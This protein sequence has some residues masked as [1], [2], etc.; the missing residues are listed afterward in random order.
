LV[1]GHAAAVLGYPS[2]EQVG[3]DQPF[4][5][6][7][8]D[9]LTAVELR[10][11]LQ[12]ETGVSLPATLVF[13]YPTATRLAGYLGS[14]FGEPQTSKAAIDKTIGSILLAKLREAGLLDTLLELADGTGKSHLEQQADEATL[15]AADVDDLVRIA[16]RTTES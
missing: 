7:G 1:R 15:L 16:L 4:K 3:G 12:A 14:L 11:R 9:S 2:G 5:E 8:F 10:N 13:D 6:L